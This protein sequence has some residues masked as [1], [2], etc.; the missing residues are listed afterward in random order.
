MNDLRTL[1]PEQKQAL[2]RA[3]LRRRP[4]AANAS[5]ASA[6]PEYARLSYDMFMAGADPEL[7]EITRFEAWVES[8]RAAGRYTFETPRRTALRPENTLVREN[9]EELPVINMASYN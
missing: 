1:T 9:G 4:S 2:L 8:S 3:A 5:D 6:L 7:S